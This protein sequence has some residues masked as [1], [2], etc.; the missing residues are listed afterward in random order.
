[1]EGITL[2]VNEK[3]VSIPV[4]DNYLISNMGRCYNTKTK[5]F[6]GSPDDRG[7]VR[8][9]LNQDGFQQSSDM[10]QLVMQYHGPPQPKGKTEIDHI[11][12]D[13]TDNRIKNLRWVSRSEN[14][15]NRNSFKMPEIEYVDEIPDTAIPLDEYNGFEYD[16][17]WFD[18]D[19]E[20]L[21][22]HSRNRFKFVNISHNGNRSRMIICDINGRRHTIGWKK[23]FQ[24]MMDR[25][26]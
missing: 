7:Y 10:H 18:Y 2:L 14:N 25:V 9:T 4:F 12:K 24:E 19:S 22:V 26:E 16:R 1:M 5:R 8:V 23:F 13:K 15:K 3:F 21:I 11:N 6:V 20:R 17:Y